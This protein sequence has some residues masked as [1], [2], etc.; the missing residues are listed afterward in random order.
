MSKRSSLLV[1]VV[2]VIVVVVCVWAFGGQL[3]NALLAMHGRH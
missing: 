2:V 3:W 1:I